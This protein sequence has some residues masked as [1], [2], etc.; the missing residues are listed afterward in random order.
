[1]ITASLSILAMLAV[2][3]AGAK[4]YRNT[5][6]SG[7]ERFQRR[8]VSQ[9]LT[10]KLHQAD[11]TGAV[12]VEAF[13]DSDA[14]VIREILDGEVYRTMVYCHNGWLMELF[15]SE[16]SMLSPSDGERIVPLRSVT[17]TENEDGIYAETVRDNGD[18]VSFYVHLRSYR[19]NEHG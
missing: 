13:G 5:V 19:E 1:M 9:Y 17:F 16:A 18:I 10:T 2:I 4:V 6:Q 12:S 15:S 3:L 8:I 14:V 7:E 11:V